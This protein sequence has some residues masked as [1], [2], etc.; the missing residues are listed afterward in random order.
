MEWLKLSSLELAGKIKKREIGVREITEKILDHIDVQDKQLNCYIK[1]CR[2]DAL[3]RADEIQKSIDQ[4]EVD[5]PLA[6]V[7]MAIKDNI[8][9]KGI[10][11]TCASKMLENFKPPYNATVVEKLM[12]AG[13][14][15]LGKLNMDEFAM[16]STS[17]TSYF[18]AVK[19]PW[20]IEKSPGGSSGGSAAAV[21]AREAFYTLATDTGGSIRKPCSYCFV[22]GLK[23]T[24]GRVSRYGLIAYASSLDQIGP[25]ASTAREC[26]AIFQVIQG[27]DERDGTSVD[28][29]YEIDEQ[30]Y[31]ND[32][33]LAGI[34]IGIPSDLMLLSTHP[35]V[36]ETVIKA[37]LKL[38]KL[39]AYFEYFPL[40]LAEYITPVYYIIAA[41]EA[42]SSM[43][44][45]DGVRFGYRPES[46]GSLEDLYINSR[47]E[48]LGAEVKKR[49]ILG[50][51]VL[52]SGNYEAYYE[53]ALKVRRMITQSFASLF[54]KYDVICALW[55]LTQH[56]HLVTAVKNI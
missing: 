53:K 41:A 45:Y 24:Y 11:T 10:E 6:G 30:I 40:P 56:Q 8:C 28:F 51:Y 37:A 43:S 54:E 13:A 25:I 52:S 55:L 49:I 7:P 22:T 42:S 16:G 26:E 36:V 39:G 21:A 19:N 17:E 38:E 12:D 27:K 32:K 3:K 15:L 50:T 47:S 48:A 46:S 1:V 4:G 14:V 29:S 44:R 2:D 31:I 20:N 33:P 35:E 5:S 23:P 9:T 34:K 18:G